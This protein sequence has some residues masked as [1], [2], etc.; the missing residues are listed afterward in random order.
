MIPAF[1]PSTG[2][3]PQGNT[4]PAGTMLPF[5]MGGNGHRVQLLTSLLS[6]CRNIAAAGCRNL[7]LDGSSFTAKLL[8]ADYDVAW[9][10]AGVNWNLLV[11]LDFSKR[12]EEGKVFWSTV[13]CL[14]ECTAR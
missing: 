13:P 1:D 10:P 2:Y 6:V 3:L 4:A 5:A 8:P 11:P 14:G 12:R 7:L 9:E